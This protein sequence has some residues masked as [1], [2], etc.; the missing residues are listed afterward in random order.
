M[1]SRKEM[2]PPLT[3]GS[4]IYPPKQLHHKHK[5]CKYCVQDH[6][7]PQ[8]T[9]GPFCGIYHRRCWGY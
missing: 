4:H 1:V 8:K 6:H 7:A 5:G 9:L 3:V 2:Q